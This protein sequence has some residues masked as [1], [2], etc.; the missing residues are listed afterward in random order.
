MFSFE[1]ESKGEMTTECS[2]MVRKKP[3]HKTSEIKHYSGPV[4]NM[5]DT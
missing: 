5:C 3:K 1:N 2:D 4:L